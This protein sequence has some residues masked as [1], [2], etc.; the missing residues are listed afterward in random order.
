IDGKN[1]PRNSLLRTVIF[2]PLAAAIPSAATAPALIFVGSLMV[3]SLKEIEWEDT[4]EGLPAFI[5]MV[6]MPLT[7]SIATGITLG[8]IFYPIIKL[9]TGK[10][11]QVNVMTW[12]LAALF[13]LYL[14]FLH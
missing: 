1:A 2:S 6:S 9:F 5:T 11:K 7:Y 12:I 14:I 4:T 10:Y 8:M 13:I 3:M